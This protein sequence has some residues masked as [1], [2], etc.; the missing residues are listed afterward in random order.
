[1]KN[2]FEDLMNL[3]TITESFYFVDH[4]FVGRKY[5]VFTY[6]LASFTDF[7]HKNALEC[8]G[9]TF[10]YINGNWRLVS[11][12]MNKFFNYD[13]HIGWGQEIDL[14]GN[15]MIMDKLDGSLISTVYNGKYIVPRWK[16]KTSFT[17]KQAQDA[18]HWFTFNADRKMRD[19]VVELSTAGYTVNFEWTAPDNTIVIGYNEPKLTVINARNMNDGSYLPYNELLYL[20]GEDNLVRIHDIP[21]DPYKFLED[22]RSLTGIE[23]YVIQTA[24]GLLVKMKTEAYCS[25]HRLR[26][27]VTNDRRLFETCVNEASDDARALFVHDKVIVDRIVKMEEKVSNIFNHIHKSVYDFYNKNKHLDRKSYAILGQEKLNSDGIFSLAMNLYLG[28]E[29]DIKSFMIKNYKKYG[30]KDEEQS[31]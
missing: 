2:L 17:S 6:R 25:L 15:I 21:N 16:S 22:S 13:E 30:I 24:S 31:E 11:L 4:E 3:C 26:E 23:G 1:M 28:K 14:S 20:F 19:S 10:E 29:C 12:P 27:S 5:R 7:Q 9:H 8:R 18:A